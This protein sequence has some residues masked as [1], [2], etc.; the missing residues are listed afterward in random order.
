MAA[1]FHRPC[2]YVGFTAPRQT[3]PICLRVQ[4]QTRKGA[5]VVCSHHV[6]VHETKM[7]KLFHTERHHHLNT[8]GGNEIVPQKY[9]RFSRVPLRISKAQTEKLCN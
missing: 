9:V 7:P 3:E 8:K 1:I 4:S 5:V 6:M 2:P